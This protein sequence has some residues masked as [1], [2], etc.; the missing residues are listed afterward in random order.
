MKWMVVGLLVVFFGCGSSLNHTTAGQS[1]E[2]PVQ[3][4][5]YSYFAGYRGW[6]QKWD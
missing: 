2:W 4:Q 3:G 1:I 6:C 5:C